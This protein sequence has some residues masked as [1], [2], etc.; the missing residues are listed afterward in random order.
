M[1]GGRPLKFK[2]VEEL[3]VRIEAYFAS[4]W[5]E[6]PLGMEDPVMIKPFTIA[7]LAVFL[8]TSRQTLLNYEKNDKFFVTL[9]G[10][11]DRIEAWAEEQLYRSK[12]VAGPIFNLKNNYSQW[13]DKQEHELSAPGG[14]PLAFNITITDPEKK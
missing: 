8:N 5:K 3:Q 9:K 7:G 14:K 6:D 1:P 2:T 4:C 10:A 11:K 13:S 12:Q